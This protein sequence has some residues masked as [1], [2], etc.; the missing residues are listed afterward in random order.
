M[1]GDERLLQRGPDVTAAR[2][3]D[4]VVDEYFT[5]LDRIDSGLEEFEELALVTTDIEVLEMI[6]ALRRDLLRR[7]AGDEGEAVLAIYFR[8]Q[9]YL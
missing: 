4:V 3:L 6:N 9:G 1:R 7:A 2:V 5:V 8:E